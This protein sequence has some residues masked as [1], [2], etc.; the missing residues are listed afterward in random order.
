MSHFC[1]QILLFSFIQIFLCSRARK[2]NRPQ[3]VENCLAEKR[4]QNGQVRT[5]SFFA[6]VYFRVP[7]RVCYAKY[8]RIQL[9]FLSEKV[10]NFLGRGSYLITRRCVFALSTLSRVKPFLRPNSLSSKR[11][12]SSKCRTDQALL[13]NNFCSR[14]CFFFIQSAF[15]SSFAGA[16]MRIVFLFGVNL[17]IRKYAQLQLCAHIL[18]FC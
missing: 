1:V 13:P 17:N 16:C 5:F 2:I 18:I 15:A 14:F 10:F 3:L 12:Y 4:L 7:N 11:L 9:L 8:T 6:I